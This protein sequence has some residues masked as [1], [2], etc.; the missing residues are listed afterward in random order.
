MAV[1]SNA[2]FSKRGQTF[3]VDGPGDVEA[4]ADAG[5]QW[6]RLPGHVAPRSGSE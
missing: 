5:S 4:D 1:A 2:P 3:A 6:R